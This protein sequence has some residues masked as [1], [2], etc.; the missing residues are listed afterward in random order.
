MAWTPALR[1]HYKSGWSRAAGEQGLFWN[2]WG[3]SASP[4]E[5]KCGGLAVRGASLRTCLRHP[6][7]SEVETQVAGGGEL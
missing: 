3:A 1:G 7:R 5:V 6:Q 4:G 2:C